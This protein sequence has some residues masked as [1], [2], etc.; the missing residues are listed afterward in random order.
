MAVG[1]IAI[2]NIVGRYQSQNIVTTLH[3]E[4]ITQGSDEEAI[5]GALCTQWKATHESGL[6]AQLNDQ[7]T[8]IG[9]KAFNKVGS[10][11]VPGYVDSGTAGTVVD[12]GLP[13][14]VNKTITLYTA[15]AKY[16][17]RGRFTMSGVSEGEL[18]A[19]DGSILPA[20][21]TIMASFG[22][23]LLVN[24]SG[25]GDEWRLCIPAVGADPVEPIVG[26]LARPKP[27]I[28]KS[29]RIREFLIG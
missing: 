12:T 15:S 10:A 29:R 28:L 24:V 25:G 13:A 20:T 9:Y 27:T 3:Y 1:D 7:M 6:V 26:V 21:L 2:L 8:I 19:S 5:L 17:R 18:V 14:F 16:R 4:V 22:A 23:A 11:T